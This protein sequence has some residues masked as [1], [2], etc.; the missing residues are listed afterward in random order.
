MRQHL[1]FGQADNLAGWDRHPVQAV[2]LRV[3]SEVAEGGVLL[4]QAEVLT[5]L[6][7]VLADPELEGCLFGA[8]Q[9]A[10]DLARATQDRVELSG[11]PRFE[12][13]DT[14]DRRDLDSDLT[15]LHCTSLTRS[16][17]CAQA[18]PRRSQT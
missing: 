14:E 12:R 2:A 6:R 7:G 10:G 5:R 16:E 8:G 13:G 4:A 11:E 17:P 15:A 9:R 1:G 18:A 3:D